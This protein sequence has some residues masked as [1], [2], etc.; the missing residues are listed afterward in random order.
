M[1]T[2][3]DKR[4]TA[5]TAADDLEAEGIAARDAAGNPSVLAE[6]I[7]DGA[8]IAPVDDYPERPYEEALSDQG[9][10]ELIERG[11][12]EGEGAKFKITAPNSEVPR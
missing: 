10:A 2:G 6:E 11:Q 1:A 7:A 12:A 5:N 3:G 8:E 4:K 9:R